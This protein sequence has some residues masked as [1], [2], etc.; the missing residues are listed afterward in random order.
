MTN[1][2]DPVKLKAAAEHLEWVCQQ[3]PNEEKVQG[4]YKALQPMIEDAKAGA[5]QR[6]VTERN[7]IPG[8]WAVS[9]EG[10]F[11]EY[12]DPSVESAYVAFGTQMA[13]GLSEQEQRIMASMAAMRDQL[14]QGRSS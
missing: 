10:L 11:R 2:I 8:N 12:A 6:P 3:Y 4:L 9:A 13:G 5:I 7:E 1:Q 14:S